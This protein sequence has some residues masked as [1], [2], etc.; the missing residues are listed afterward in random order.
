[1]RWL[2]AC[3]LL[4]TLVAGAQSQETPFAEELA[5]LARKGSDPAARQSAWDNLAKG[6]P[7]LLPRILLAMNGADTTAANWLRTAFDRIADRAIKAGAKMIDADALLAFAV[8]PKNSGRARRLALDLVEG[9]RPGT[10]NRQVAGWLEDPEFR[11]DAVAQQLEAAKILAQ[12]ATKAELLA[13]YRK[14]FQAARDLTQASA[15]AAGLKELGQTV[16]VAEH[17]GILLDWY[18]IGPFD[19]KGQKGFFLSYPPEKKVDLAEELDGQKGK[20]RWKHY[21]VK[22]GARFQALVDLRAPEAL[23]ETDDAVAFAYTEFSALKAGKVEF[24]GA[25]DDNFTVWVNGVKVFGFEEYRN[26]VRFDRHRFSAEL[27]AGKNSVLVKI[28][29]SPPPN[30][31]RNWEFFLRVV[32]DTGKGIAM[33]NLIAK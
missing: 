26:G 17:F 7:D 10:F 24:N 30:S 9:L 32:D 12:K 2:A 22:E 18:L 28:I 20:V 23:G 21:K 27:K 13:L 31:E 3:V 15:A 25:A 8:D 14:A 29:E 16:S 11:F 6:G 19:A 33:K 1:M 5:I 4:S